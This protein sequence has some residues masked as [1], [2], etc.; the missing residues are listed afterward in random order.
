MRKEARSDFSKKL[1]ENRRTLDSLDQ[2]LLTLLNQ[3]L[4]ITLKIGK[5]KKGIGKRIYDPDREKEILE[6]L[7]RKNKGPLNE[8]DLKKIF[9]TI[10]KV[11]RR[12][13]I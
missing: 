6:R 12:S 1:K 2:K 11:C 5:I 8:K 13:Q 7:Q 4:H 3:R 10:M 9:G